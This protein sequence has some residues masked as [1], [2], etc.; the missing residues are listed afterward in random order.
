[1]RNNWRDACTVDALEAGANSTSLSQFPERTYRPAKCDFASDDI[2]SQGESSVSKRV[3][4][5][6]LL[7]T[8]RRCVVSTV[9]YDHHRNTRSHS[10]SEFVCG[11]GVEL[12]AARP[13][14]SLSR[15]DREGASRSET[16]E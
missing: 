9:V 11:A 6:M 5:G 2:Y 7:L 16:G 8:R 1:M 3:W 13:N 10:H 15:E 12:D 4:S 14:H